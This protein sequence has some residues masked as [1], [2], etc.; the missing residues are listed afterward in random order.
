MDSILSA[1]IPLS[2]RL[3]LKCVIQFYCCAVFTSVFQQF[4]SYL[5]KLGNPCHT[6]LKQLHKQRPEGQNLQI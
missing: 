5:Q 6:I 1:G 2:L 4:I 3:P